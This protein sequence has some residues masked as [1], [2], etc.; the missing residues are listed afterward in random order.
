M[1]DARYVASGWRHLWRRWLGW[2]PVQWCMVCHAG[3]WGGL[4]RRGWRAWVADYCS[5]ICARA[6]EA[7]WDINEGDAQVVD[8]TR[9]GTNS[10][11]WR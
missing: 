2:F 9:G 6:D 8:R 10:C 4:P 1:G 11:A 7:D 3:Y 5:S